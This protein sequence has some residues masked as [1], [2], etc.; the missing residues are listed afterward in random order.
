MRYLTD[1]FIRGTLRLKTTTA[2]GATATATTEATSAAAEARHGKEK[3]ADFFRQ[4]T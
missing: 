1:Y 3:R 4:L 2:A